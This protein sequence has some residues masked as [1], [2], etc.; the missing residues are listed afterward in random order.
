LAGDHSF[1]AGMDAESRAAHRSNLSV[2]ASSRYVRFESIRIGVDAIIARR[3]DCVR[4][5]RSV[6]FECSLQLADV[7]IEGAL[8]K[9]DL[10]CLIVEI[11]ELE[12]CLRSQSKSGPRYVNL[13]ARSVV[14]KQL[15]ADRQ[16][17]VH[18]SRNPL[19]D[20]SGLKRNRTGNIVEPPRAGGWV[21]RENDARGRTK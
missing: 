7:N 17:T 14:R 1:L 16:R 4:H 3:L 10:S 11:Q 6:Y 2:T 5:V 15:V 18:C 19:I 8:R 21:L 20:A 9:L 13:S 12:G